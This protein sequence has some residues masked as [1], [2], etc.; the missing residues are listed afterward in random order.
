MNNYKY[1]L[2]FLVS[3]SL[4]TLI[5]PSIGTTIRL[6]PFSYTLTHIVG[7]LVITSEKNM[8]TESWLRVNRNS[9]ML[10]VGC[11]G[12]Q[13]VERIGLIFLKLL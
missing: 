6:R 10:T 4:I 8:A 13:Q 2:L 11:P 1:I 12:R 5:L 9:M 7:T 3:I